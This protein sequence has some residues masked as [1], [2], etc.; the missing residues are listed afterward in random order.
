MA[1]I[2]ACEFLILSGAISGWYWRREKRFVMGLPLVRS[3]FRTVIFHLGTAAFGSLIVAIIQAIRLLFE[4]LQREL[5]TATNGNRIVKGC[6]WYV[7]VLLWII[8]KIIKF[9]NRQAYV[10]CAMYGTGFLSS[11]KNAFSKY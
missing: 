5:E 2:Q 8:E 7:R 11:A 10:Q 3:F 9:F 6:G 4:K 1:F